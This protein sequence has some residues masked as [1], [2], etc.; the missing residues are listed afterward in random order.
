MGENQQKSEPITTD[1]N[2]LLEAK[3]LS[4]KFDYKLFENINLTLKSQETIA[5]IGKS[6]SGKSTLLNILSS[7]LKPESGEVIYNKKD[8]YKEKK[9][10]F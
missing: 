3:N 7:L 6:G 8:I 9:I 4:H 5:I 10:S 2:I 1:E